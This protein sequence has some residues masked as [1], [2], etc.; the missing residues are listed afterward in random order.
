MIKNEERLGEVVS[1]GANG[2]GVLRENQYVIFV[3][4]SLPGEKIK[5]K[6]LK[7]AKNI[8]YG[9]LLEVIVPSNNRVQ[10][11][12]P[13]FTKCG[14]C[15][16]QH[17]V[18]QE[19]LESKREQ[20]KQ[21]FYKIANLNVD[22]LPVVTGESE[23]NYRNKLQLPVQAN[24]NGAILGFYAENS[25]RVIQVEDCYTS[26]LW[27]KDV[28]KCFKDYFKEFNV[29]GYD[30]KTFSGDIREIT[31]K[32]INN[33]LIITV[34]SCQNTIKGK[35]RLIEILKQGIKLNFSLYININNN[36][37]NVIYGEQFKHI[38]GEKDYYGE[39]FG[40]KYKIGVKSFMQ[41][42][43]SVC[44]K[45]YQTVRDKLN[46]DSE[47]VVFDAY[48][49]AGLM[50]ALLSKN[51][52]K[53]IGIEIIEEAVKLADELAI[54]NG[55]SSVIKNYCGKCE[56]ILPN[57]IRREKEQASKISVV[58]D[59]PRKGVDINVI[60]AIIKSDI[61]KIVYVS[62]MPSTL[63]RDVGLITGS[64]E[65]VDGKIVKSDKAT[66]RYT[67]TEVIP[68]DMFAQTKHV[69]TLVVLQ[70]K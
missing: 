41:I 43:N 59:P 27:T 2:E 4:Y 49:G 67:I 69:E 11:V 55:L 21:C 45:L 56:E 17:L 38:Y 70:R 51:A 8:V 48:S 66:H 34:V 35:E 7:V 60:N 39:M 31:V 1:L 14:G 20:I 57:L 24:E 15:Q 30:E 46:A 64:L 47:T 6:V 19:Q 53:A 13:V 16:L 40:I 44:R 18:Y 3:P 42:N 9:K 10:P 50:T 61:E 68:F 5:Y 52:K 25:H 36:R 62:C 12:C 23:Y 29:K 22:V 65:Y 58:L 32:E 33:N 28:I 63:A 37:N 54:D 26:A